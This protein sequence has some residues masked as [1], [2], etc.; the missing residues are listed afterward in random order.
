MISA[1]TL[2][3]FP[4][5][6]GGTKGGCRPFVKEGHNNPLTPSDA[7]RYGVCDFVKGE[8]FAMTSASF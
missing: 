4:L 7:F 6:K 3:Q 8:Y 2:Q 5:N 1:L